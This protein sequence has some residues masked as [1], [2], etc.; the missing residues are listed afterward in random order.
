[1]AVKIKK[2]K[3]QKK[4]IENEYVQEF[5]EMKTCYA[6]NF[7]PLDLSVYENDRNYEFYKLQNE[8][9]ENYKKTGKTDEAIIWKMFP[10][11]EGV[12]GSLA[13]KFVATG[14]HVPHFEE[15]V[16]DSALAVCEHYRNQPYFRAEKLENYA[17]HKVRE[18]FY[19]P[20]TQLNERMVDYD[21]F[22]NYDNDDVIDIWR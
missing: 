3:N 14:C 20:N 19:D 5:E 7:Q 12:C 2:A 18:V 8:L 6:E 17:F 13:K 22:A 21:S 9:L 4:W 16:L 1:M 15:K 10:F 11:I